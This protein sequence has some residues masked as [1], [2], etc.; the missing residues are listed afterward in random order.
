MQQMLTQEEIIAIE[1]ELAH[2]DRRRAACIDALKIVQQR[3]GWV[4]DDALRGIADL[5]HMSVD[6]LDAVEL[7]DRQ[8]LAQLVSTIALFHAELAV[9]ALGARARL[10]IVADQRHRRAAGLD[11]IK[12][13][14]HRR[15]AVGLSRLHLRHDA[16]TSLHHGD[17]H[18]LAVRGV[19]PR[20]ADFSA[21][22]RLCHRLLN[23]RD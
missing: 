17:G 9:E 16:R 12:A 4:P 13:D 6:E 5:L 2:Y 18:I 23:L 10:G 14:L 1:Q 22:D 11:V 15:V 8:A 20:H 7:L 3:R 19:D 21:K